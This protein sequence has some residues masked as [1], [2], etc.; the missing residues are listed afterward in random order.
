MGLSQDEVGQFLGVSFQQTQ[1]YENATNRIAV[2][3]FYDLSKAL[4]VRTSY[5]LTRYPAIPLRCGRSNW[6]TLRL[7][8][9][10]ILSWSEIPSN[11]RGPIMGFPMRVYAGGCFNW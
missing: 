1:K 7:L 8:I 11:L 9:G 2:S 4:G 10:L 6:L 3:G 5:F